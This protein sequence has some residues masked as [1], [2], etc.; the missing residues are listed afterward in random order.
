MAL[1]TGK[2]C[3][4]LLGVF[5]PPVLAYLKR[6]CGLSFCISL[7]LWVFIAT[8]PIAIIYTFHIANY[9]DLCA[10]ILCCLLP[11]VAAFMRFSCG[12]KFWMS[13]I[14]WIFAFVPSIVYTYYVTW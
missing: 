11:P 4:V 6:G 8:W 14:L 7:L 2:L 12:Y 13:L 10:N 9:S 1:D 5:I 3:D